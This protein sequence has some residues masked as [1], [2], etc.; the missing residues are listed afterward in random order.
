[1]PPG[2]R[3]K[4]A[5]VKN[6]SQLRTSSEKTHNFIDICYV[7]SQPSKARCGTQ[8]LTENDASHTRDDSPQALGNEDLSK[9]QDHQRRSTNLLPRP[10]QEWKYSGKVSS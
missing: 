10:N 7:G 5:M 9:E 4:L 6:H 1:M 3:I 2:V 8:H